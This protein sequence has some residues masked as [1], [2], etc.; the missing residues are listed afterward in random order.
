LHPT[1]GTYLSQ[2]ALADMSGVPQ[3]QISRFERGKLSPTLEEVAALERA[4]DLEKGAL[5]IAA[6]AIDR[7][8]TFED[9]VHQD[10]ILSQDA[11]EFVLD[12]YGGYVR[13]SAAQD[14][15]GGLEGDD[16]DA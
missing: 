14:A 6:Q 7:A 13:K 16:D 5:L 8:L 12:W 10:P 3:H 15:D 1:T 2:D 4:L 11:K 9:A